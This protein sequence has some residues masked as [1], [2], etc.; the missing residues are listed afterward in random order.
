MI[1]NPRDDN[2]LAVEE[3]NVIT[4]NLSELGI[5]PVHY[6]A[7]EKVCKEIQNKG[8]ELRIIK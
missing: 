2:E 7:V 1:L 6:D 4:L 5:D 3:S 8:I